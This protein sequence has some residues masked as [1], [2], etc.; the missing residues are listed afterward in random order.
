MKIMNWNCRG[1]GNPR[2]VQYP[3]LLTQDKLPN[4]VFIM[5]TKLDIDRMERIKR[6]IGFYGCLAINTLCRSGGLA[7]LWRKEGMMKIYKYS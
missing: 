6:K 2:S 3:R 1:L 7:L 5:K 4:A